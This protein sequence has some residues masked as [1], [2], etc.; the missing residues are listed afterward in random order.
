VRYLNR[1][2][3]RILE[4]MSDKVGVPAAEMEFQVFINRLWTSCAGLMILPFGALAKATGS[5]TFGGLAIASFGVMLALSVRYF[6]LRHRCYLVTSVALNY[7]INWRH[8]VRGVPNWRRP[9]SQE[10]LDKLNRQYAAWCETRGVHLDDSHDSNQQS[11]FQRSR[12]TSDGDDGPTCTFS[13][14]RL[15]R[16]K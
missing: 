15:G 7:R 8:P 4:R 13:D 12:E 3:S 1:V 5:W 11:N 16:W 6:V 2:H 14:W 9:L 10:Q